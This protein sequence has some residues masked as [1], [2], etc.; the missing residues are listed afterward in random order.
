[1]HEIRHLVFSGRY[2]KNRLY[3]ECNRIHK[4]NC[5]YHTA[6]EF[7]RT[8]TTTVFQSRA[9]AEKFI[10]EHDN[11]FYDQIAVKFK[12]KTKTFWLAKIEYHV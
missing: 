8:P 3:N 9:E 2:E 7:L 6:L 12:D 11:G 10:E 5:E 4:S 1:M